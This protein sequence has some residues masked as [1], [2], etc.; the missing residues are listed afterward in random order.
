MNRILQPIVALYWKIRLLG[1]SPALD[2]YE[3]RKL[4]IFNIL[5]CMGILNGIVIPVAGL[6][7]NDKLPA[8]A[9]VVAISPALIS[10]F[11]LMAIRRRKYEQGKMIYFIFYPLLTALAYA[12]K[13]DVGIELFFFVYAVLAVFLLQRIINAIVSF[14]FSVLLYFAVFVVWNDYETQLAIVNPGFYLF[15]HVLAAL[16]IFCSLYLFK[17]ENNA[18]LGRLENNNR[19]L[20]K[21]N[22]EI[23]EQK[24]AIA[25]QVGLLEKQTMELQELDGLKNKLFSVIAHDLK[26]P[27][28]ALRNLFRNIQQYDLPGE[29]IKLMIPDVVTDLNYT[30]GLMENL[31]QWAKSQM[32]SDSM[33][34]QTVDLNELI[35]EVIQLLRLQA[36]AKK[37]YIENK[38]DEPVYIYAD[39]EMVNLVLR[40]LLS[41]AIK[42]T[43]EE[44]TVF[45]GANETDGFV[46]VFVQDNGRGMS[47][48]VLRKINTNNYFTTKGT[49]NE[50][51][52]GL[53]LM[54][55]KD[56][57]AKNGGKMFVE[58][59]PG[60]G[61]VFSFTLPANIT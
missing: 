54:L 50:S 14:F 36:D 3:K 6:F 41:N 8:L 32:Q 5:N 34:K 18:Y 60:K 35:R 21:K 10:S 44:G 11:A 58:S 45:L 51:G 46:E 49:S 59:E 19:E 61:S 38:L 42:F 27:M 55:C 40:N 24:A 15:N 22:I 17:T 28:Y 16:F 4:A 9:W 37:L 25:L 20:E 13:I 29:E 1:D 53:G 39:K 31:L 52:T 48:E 57:L 2:E 47:D 26:T 12:T 7:N 43:P 33:R 56:F 23:G 30:T